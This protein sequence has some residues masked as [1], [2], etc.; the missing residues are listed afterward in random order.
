[1]EGF[2]EARWAR[3]ARPGGAIA[4]V[5]GGKMPLRGALSPGI[6]IRRLLTHRRL[7]MTDAEWIADGWEKTEKGWKKK[8]FPEGNTLQHIEKDLQQV[9]NRVALY[10]GQPGMDSLVQAL[11]EII[12]AQSADYLEEVTEDGPLLKMKIKQRS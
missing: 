10:P 9:M 11:Y 12:M 4:R 3:R 8:M 1:L 7:T 5:S 2:K 6:G